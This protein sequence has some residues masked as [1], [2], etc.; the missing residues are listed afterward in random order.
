MQIYKCW[1]FKDYRFWSKING[2]APGQPVS[3]HLCWIIARLSRSIV[4]ADS[5]KNISQWWLITK[6]QWLSHNCRQFEFTIF[7]NF[8]FNFYN[9]SAF[10]KLCNFFLVLILICASSL[11]SSQVL[12]TS[13][14]WQL[15]SIPFHLIF[16]HIYLS[17]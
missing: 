13:W 6:L 3:A 16:C 12:L 9:L 2:Q 14:N 8:R 15:E 17:H 1:T 10:S 5:R 11:E 4:F 7:Y